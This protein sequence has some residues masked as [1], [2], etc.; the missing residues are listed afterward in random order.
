MVEV[1]ALKEV[2]QA[3]PNP[4]AYVRQRPKQIKSGTVLGHKAK[5]APR[6]RHQ[7]TQKEAQ[8]VAG[9]RK[10]FNKGR[11]APAKSKSYGLL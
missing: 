1:Q 7:V 5:V 9:P 11:L 10:E 6:V 8:T 4:K 2:F 3:I